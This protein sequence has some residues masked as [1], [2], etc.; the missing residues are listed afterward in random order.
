MV[1]D[2]IHPNHVVHMDIAYGG[3]FTKDGKDFFIIFP[4]RLVSV[5]LSCF[6]TTVGVRRALCEIASPLF[7]CLW[8]IEMLLLQISAN[9]SLALLCGLL[10]SFVMLWWMTLSLPPFSISWVRLLFMTHLMQLLRISTIKVFF[11]VKSYYL[12]SSLILPS[13]WSLDFWGGSLG[14]SFGRVWLP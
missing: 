14:K 7:L 10:I 1:L 12:S 9:V 13:L 3:S 5:L 8:W 11:T 2:G 4:S 6:D